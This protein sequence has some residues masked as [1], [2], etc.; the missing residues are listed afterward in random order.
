MQEME[1]NLKTGIVTRSAVALDLSAHQF[2][3][4]EAYGQTEPG[5]TMVPGTAPIHLLESVLGTFQ[6]LGFDT[7]PGIRNLKL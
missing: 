6:L 4:L 5:S 2:D 1:T 7:W 3:Q